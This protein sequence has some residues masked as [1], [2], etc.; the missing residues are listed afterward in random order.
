M[1]DW[2]AR[3]VNADTVAAM[4]VGELVLEL[5]A[6]LVVAAV[7]AVAAALVAVES[8]V[9]FVPEVAL[10]EFKRLDRSEAWL[11]LT[12]PIDITCFYCDRWNQVVGRELENF[13]E[14]AEKLL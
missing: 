2:V 10:D 4:L 11:L 9:E 14:R 12:L 8:A 6:S 5:D 7:L 3:I 13:S 1:A